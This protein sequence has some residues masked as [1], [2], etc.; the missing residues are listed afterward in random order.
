VSQLSGSKFLL[1]RWKKGLAEYH[2]VIFAKKGAGVT[3]LADLQGKMIAFE[4]PFSTS[5]YFLPKAVLL[6][7]GFTLV[8]KSGPAEAVSPREVGYVL[9]DDDESTMVWVLKGRVAAGAMDPQN[10]RKYAGAQME[11]LQIVHET[12]AIPRQIVSYRADLSP[13][14]V[15]RIKDVLLRMHESDEGRKALQ[16]FER[17]TKFDELPPDAMTPVL[18]LQRFIDGELRGK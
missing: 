11:N 15:S 18:K 6:E 16:E 8:P 9:T 10:L 12:F 17:T 7:H 13:T 3:R 14:L 1:R 5:G 2:T 4:E